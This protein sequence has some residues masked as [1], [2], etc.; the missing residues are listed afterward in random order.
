[1]SLCEISPKWEY[2][3]SYMTDIKTSLFL[4]IPPTHKWML[5]LHSSFILQSEWISLNK[6]EDICVKWQTHII[7]A[8]QV[9]A[10]SQGHKNS[11]LLS[12]MTWLQ[13]HE[14]WNI[15][16]EELA[17]VFSYCVHFN[18]MICL[19]IVRIPWDH[20]VYFI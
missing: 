1:M 3:K 2:I 20:D 18:L 6:I 14:D 19:I 17:Y 12:R 5:F 10:L 16:P 11:V 7:P 9:I 4:L 15:S 13:I 8:Q